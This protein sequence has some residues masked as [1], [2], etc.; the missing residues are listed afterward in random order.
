M[1]YKYIDQYTPPQQITSVTINNIT[2]STIYD[3]SNFDSLVDSVG[4]GKIFIPTEQPECDEGYYAKASYVD[5]DFITMV[6]EVV[7]VIK[8]EFKITN[9]RVNLLTDRADATEL[10]IFGM[11]I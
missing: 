4:T 6:W 11:M 1:R 2:T 8:D 9:E 5:G 10:A 3:S 7:E